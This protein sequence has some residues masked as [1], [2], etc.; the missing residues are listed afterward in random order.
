MVLFVEPEFPRISHISA[1]AAHQGGL[2]LR[3]GRGRPIIIRI[4]AIW[5]RM[6]RL[7]FHIRDS[8][9]IDRLGSQ[10]PSGALVELNKATSL[11]SPRK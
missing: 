10:K 3:Y 5:F 9:E 6:I 2:V 11:R 7:A 8:Q 4:Q 1:Y